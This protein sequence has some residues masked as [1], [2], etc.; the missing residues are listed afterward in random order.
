LAAGVS[1]I[2][3]LHART[4]AH[5][6]GRIIAIGSVT[7]GLYIVNALLER[8]LHG[9]GAA[10]V[11]SYA[12]DALLYV[13]VTAAIL[14]AYCSVLSMCRRGELEAGRARA[15]S[16]ILPCA[17]QLGLAVSAP[18]LSQDIYSYMAHGFLGIA[19]GHNPLTDEA[20]MAR[21]TLIGPRLAAAGWDAE[22]GRTPYGIIWTQIEINIMRVSRADVVVAQLLMKAVVLVSSL[23]TALGIWCFLS[24]V[25]PPARLLGALAYLW[26]PLI[27]IELPG[28][29]HN[30]ALMVLCAVAALAAC[31]YERSGLSVFAQLCGVLTKYVNVLFVPAQLVYLWRTRRTAG[32]RLL[33]ILAAVCVA[34]AMA[35]VLYAPLWAGVHS[36]DGIAHRAALGSSAAP[37]GVIEWFM[38]RSPLAPAAEELTLVSVGLAALAFIAWIS[39]RVKEAAGLARAFAWISI[40][41]VLVASPDYWPWYASMPVTLLIVAYTDRYLWLIVLMSAVARLG[42]PLDLLREDGVLAMGL[43]TGGRTGMGTTL[44]LIALLIWGLR[45]TWKREAA[46]VEGM[47]QQ[48]DGPQ[49]V[50]SATAA[51]VQVNH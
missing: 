30:D 49:P 14:G 50:S 18:Q 21:S 34:A 48:A 26:N 38:M 45:H 51:D 33:K 22:P 43:S 25:N 37:S 7:A 4:L 32:G 44:P 40:A 20:E 41:Y 24:R 12:C 9:N 35:V 42:A 2:P 47:T 10:G 39:L 29:G 46:A 27:L 17:L 6:E 1:D 8:A 11:T 19:P 15:W 28:E 23:G 13:L 3:A 5:A 36:F 16:L 31:A